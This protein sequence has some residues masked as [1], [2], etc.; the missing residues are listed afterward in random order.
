[1]EEASED[2]LTLATSQGT[3]LSIEVD[4]VTYGGTTSYETEDSDME[5]HQESMGAAALLI[6][7]GG[8]F[9]GLLAKKYRNKRR[10]II[11]GD[12]QPALDNELLS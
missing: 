1:M 12:E 5:M 6:L 3:I 9:S 7:L 4:G 8:L 2:D 10:V 11:S